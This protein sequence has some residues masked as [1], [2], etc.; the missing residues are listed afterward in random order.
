M[1]STTNQAVQM[2]DLSPAEALAVL[3]SRILADGYRIVMDL[4]GSHGCYLRD[5]LS[6]REFLDF[7]SFFASM[8]V[9]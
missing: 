9:G 3:K 8:P 4:D 1:A 6:G 7:Y 5:G 2:D